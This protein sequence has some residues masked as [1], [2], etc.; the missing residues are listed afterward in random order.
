VEGRREDSPKEVKMF[1]TLLVVTF[2]IAVVVSSIVVR[3]FAK[4]ISDILARIITD[5]IAVAWVR[6]VKFAI[7]VVG[8]SGGVRIYE[9]QRYITP[10]KAGETPI[11][12]NAQRWILEIY[13]TVIEA[14]QSIAWMLLVFF[15]C[16]LIA[17]VIVRVFDRRRVAD[18]GK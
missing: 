4:S 1:I 18:E 7:Y 10:E 9:L 8:V 16:A 11:E 5:E 3:L 13:R 17:Y 12:L 15:V 6:Y 2:L 14:L